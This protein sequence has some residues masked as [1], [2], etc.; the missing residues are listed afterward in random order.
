[1]CHDQGGI[2]AELD[3]EIPIGNRVQR[4]AAHFFEFQRFRHSFPIDWKC[5]AC[6]CSGAQRETIDAFSAIPQTFDVTIEHFGIRQQ[7]MAE[8]NRLGDLHMGETGQNRVEM[9]FG[10]I[11]QGFAQTMQ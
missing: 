11:E 7:M 2:G 10:Q 4:I 9:L 1:M 8:G 3:S 5:R 6:Q